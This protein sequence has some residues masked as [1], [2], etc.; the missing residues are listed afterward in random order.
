L[1][2]RVS[3]AID[4]ERDP[5]EQEKLFERALSIGKFGRAEAEHAGVQRRVVG[6]RGALRGEHVIV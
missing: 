4:G 3:R 2:V 5:L 6:P 1:L